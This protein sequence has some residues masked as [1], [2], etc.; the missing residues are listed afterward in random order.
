MNVQQ[1]HELREASGYFDCI[2][3]DFEFKSIFIEKD[4]F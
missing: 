2:E 4:P 1:Q 3:T